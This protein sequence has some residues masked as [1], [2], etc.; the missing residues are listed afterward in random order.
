MYNP[1]EALA[2]AIIKSAA[3]DYMKEIKGQRR[4]SELKKLE[5]FFLSDWFTALTSVDGKWLMQELKREVERNE[6][7]GEKRKRKS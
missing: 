7:D 3:N 1:Y 5:E 2:N 6:R 4:G